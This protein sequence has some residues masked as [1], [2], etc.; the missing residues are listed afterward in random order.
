[1]QIKKASKLRVTGLAGNSPVTG[2]FPAQRPVTRKM[3]PYDDVIMIQHYGEWLNQTDGPC[4]LVYQITNMVACT[5]GWQ[6]GNSTRLSS[7]F[8]S[9]FAWWR[10]QMETFCPLLAVCEENQL[11]TSEFPYKGQ[12]RRAWVFSLMWACTNECTASRDAGDLRRHGAHC[13]VIMMG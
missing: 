13:D 12:W 9:I 4:L 10:H 8:A 5:F 3:F 6:W 11:V 7:W 1:M 2:E